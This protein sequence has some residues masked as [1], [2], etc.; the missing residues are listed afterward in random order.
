MIVSRGTGD[1]GSYTTRTPCPCLRRTQEAQWLLGSVRPGLEKLMA[2]Q[3]GTS[4]NSHGY[5]EGS[6]PPGGEL[7]W[8]T[9][10]EEAFHPENR[11]PMFGYY[12]RKV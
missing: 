2:Q 3:E 4:V 6:S 5:T 10:H 8:W 12:L 9:L 11:Q 7:V 1:S